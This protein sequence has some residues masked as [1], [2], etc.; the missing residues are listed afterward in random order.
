MCDTI[1]ALGNS[2]SDGNVIFGKNSDRHPNEAH[3]V[4]I[5]PAAHHP[6]GSTVKCTYIEIPQVSATNQVLLAKP[7][8]IWGAEMGS[9]EHG[10]TIGNEA[11]FTRTPYGKAPGLIGMDFLRLA[12]E[13]T[14]TAESA[15]MLIINLLEQY[16]QGGNCGFDHKMYYHNSFLICD[17]R[18]AWVLETSGK[19]WA[20]E[21]VKDVRSISN[22]IT[23]GEKWDLASANLV[24]SAVKNGWCRSA[25][26]FNFARCY[27]EPIYTTFASGRSRQ[28]CTT[29]S[30]KAQKG[31]IAV[32]TMMQV[33]R[34]HT[35]E[36]RPAWSPDRKITG[37]DVCMHAG[38]GPIR[39]NQT[40][41][42]MVSVLREEG[43]SEHWVTATAVPCTSLF[44]PVWLDAGIPQTGASPTGEYDRSAL[45]WRHEAL[46][47]EISRDYQSRIKIVCAMQEKFE[48]DQIEKVTSASRYP[49]QAR[50]EISN[51]AFRQADEIETAWYEQVSTMKVSRHNRLLYRLAWK[52]L[53]AQAKLI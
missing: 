41:G 37:A 40:A 2:T 20:A 3:E 53:D 34:S 33:L 11:V 52:K 23:I 35:R 16:G 22:A 29:K 26:D 51:E 36:I 39:E 21:K 43:H 14:N 24:S 15:M 30:L 18:E 46:Q 9:N 10:V 50:K 45:Y 25:E 1:V 4:L 31:R 7:F 42:S 44:K 48:T 49:V 8:W 12:L 13:R 19:E 47:R 38:W 32:K 17:P 27:S 28:A 6:A 5:F